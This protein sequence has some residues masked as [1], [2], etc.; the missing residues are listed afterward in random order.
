MTTILE[1][2]AAIVTLLSGFAKLEDEIFH[3]NKRQLQL[4]VKK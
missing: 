3:W 1:V 2:N 4:E